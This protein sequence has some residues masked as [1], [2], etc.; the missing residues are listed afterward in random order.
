MHNPAY[1]TGSS[2]AKV[3]DAWRKLL[4]QI[5]GKNSDLTKALIAASVSSGLK[6]R[7]VLMIVKVMAEDF[8]QPVM[9]ETSHASTGHSSNHETS[10]E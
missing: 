9:P 5:S 6:P 7:Q 3:Q 2:I 4:E 10:D 1:Q 8:C